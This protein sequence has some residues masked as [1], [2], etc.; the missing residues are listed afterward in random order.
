ML[1]HWLTVGRDD[2]ALQESLVWGVACASITIEG[3]GLRC[4]AA[5]SR[6][7]LDERVEEVKRCLRDES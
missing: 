6:E 2:S 1:A 7:L 5:A 3:V 4:I